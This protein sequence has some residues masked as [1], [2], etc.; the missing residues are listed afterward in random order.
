MTIVKRISALLFFAALIFVAAPACAALPTW[1]D[2]L[3][4]SGGITFSKNSAPPFWMLANQQGRISK[5]GDGSFFS[6]LRLL[7]EPDKSK[8]LGWMYGIDLTA[9]TN[10]N[11]DLRWSDA[12]TGVSYK[13]LKLTV[14]RKA[15]FFGLADSL[16]TA[17]PEV[18]SR[19][20]PTIPKIALST[21]GYVGL[22]DWLAFNAFL[23]H[24]WMGQ[25]QYVKNA[26]LHQKFLYLRFGGTNPDKGTN[27]YTGIHHLALWGGAGN[28]S[29]FHDFAKVFFGKSGSNDA[30]ESDQVNAL[31]DHRG[32]I[33]FALQQKCCDRDWFFYA[34]TM[35]E[36]GSGLRFW[37]PGDYLLGLSLIY[38]NKES[39]IKRINVE[40]LDTRFDTASHVGNDDYFTNGEY[41]GWV[42]EGY[43]IGHPFIPFN[44]GINYTYEPQNR[45]RGFNAGV[46]LRFSKMINPLVQVAWIRNYGS[47]NNPL[48]EK[49]RSSI[50][51]CNLTNTSTLARGWTMSQQIS[52]DAGKKIE[53]APG[54][55]LTVTKSIE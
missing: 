5:E 37:S 36:D 22:N 43:A 41:S 33:E 32:S 46:L 26:Y 10:S 20:A 23:A 29:G 13:Q 48:P 21:N 1:I 53:P 7:K 31:G 50:I 9:R 2:S 17:G 54:L 27:F 55:C 24:G 14:G 15:E 18:Y 34:Q 47:F 19:N 16:L 30:T 40:L 39:R 45:M 28:P 38:K 12:Y 52:L 35:F 42:H 6:R 49:E 25:E 8:T 3:E 51:A 4:V 11:P 44:K